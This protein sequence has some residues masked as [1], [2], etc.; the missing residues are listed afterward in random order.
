MT[1]HSDQHSPHYIIQKQRFSQMSRRDRFA[2]L[3]NVHKALR[4]LRESDGDYACYSNG[5]GFNRSDSRRG[6]ELAGWPEWTFVAC[7]W[8][9]EDGLRLVHN[10]RGQL[11]HALRLPV[12]Q[13]PILAGKKKSLTRIAADR[14]PDDDDHVL[15]KSRHISKIHAD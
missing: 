6:H 12:D 2:G 14:V 13:D 7:D 15:G 10:Y 4:Y 3:V 9:H 5:K 1:N 11:P 8:M